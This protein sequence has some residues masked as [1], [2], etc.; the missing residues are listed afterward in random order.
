VGGFIVT[1]LR[2]R[3]ETMR[4]VIVLSGIPDKMADEWIQTHMDKVCEI[5]GG[6]TTVDK[7]RQIGE[8]DIVRVIPVSDKFDPDRSG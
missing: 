5:F 4:Y 2:V 1:S 6:D 8:R 7:C 3:G